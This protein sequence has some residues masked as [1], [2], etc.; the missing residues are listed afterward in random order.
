MLDQ[1]YDLQEIRY[2]P[3]PVPKNAFTEIHKSYRQMLSEA[4]ATPDHPFT[5][6]LK[7]DVK[8]AGG[9]KKR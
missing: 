5:A 9:K 1:L 4:M 6:G 2:Q 7:P 8:K 3:K